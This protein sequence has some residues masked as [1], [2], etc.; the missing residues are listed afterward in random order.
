MAVNKM[1]KFVNVSRDMPTKRM[2]KLRSK[3]YNEVYQ[4]FAAEKAEE[5]SSRCSQPSCEQA[6]SAIIKVGKIVIFITTL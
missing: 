1:L 3:D 2:P 6:I 4:E 5:Q